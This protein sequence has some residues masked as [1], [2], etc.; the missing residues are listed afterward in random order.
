[1]TQTYPLP[2]ADMTPANANYAKPRYNT[3]ADWAGGAYGD[4]V[5]T[6]SANVSLANASGGAAAADYTPR[7]QAGRASPSRT[8]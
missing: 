5:D 4:D 7:H 1:M 6:L 3:P 8:P 2:V